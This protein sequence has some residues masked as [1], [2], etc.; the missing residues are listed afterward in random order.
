MVKN[1]FHK[2]NLT[3]KDKLLAFDYTLFFSILLLGI[4]SLFAMYSSERGTI[5]YHTQSHLYRLAV[6][7]LLFIFMCITPL[8]GSLNIVNA[9]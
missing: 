8:L 9:P 6:F 7:F 2:G 4:I 1:Y 3:F 5:S